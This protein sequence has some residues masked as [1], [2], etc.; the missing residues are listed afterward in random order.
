MRRRK[1]ESYF[2]H[3]NP[4]HQRLHLG[5]RA[6]HYCNASYSSSA[7]TA[8]DW[9][10]FLVSRDC[11][12]FLQKIAV[13]IG[14]S[15]SNGEMKLKYSKREKRKWRPGCGSHSV[16]FFCRS[17]AEPYLLAL[18]REEINAI[19]LLWTRL[20]PPTT[21]EETY[22]QPAGLIPRL[23]E[24]YFLNGLPVGPLARRKVLSLPMIV[25]RFSTSLWTDG[26][27]DEQSAKKYDA[28][29]NR[30]SP[31]N[32]PFFKEG[33]ERG[34]QK[35]REISAKLL[36]T[37]NFCQQMGRDWIQVEDAQH[38]QIKQRESI[39]KLLPLL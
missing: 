12:S 29:S 11:I 9:L 7:I 35:R 20:Q 36:W 8:R 24:F 39:S 18:V 25:A 13:H 14:G 37:T 19:R 28:R 3:T 27:T 34:K 10:P 15:E 16:A 17:V 38:L 4:I 22:V 32:N 31:I 23:G 21:K 30:K 6:A 33:K 26:R 5:C 1:S 2:G